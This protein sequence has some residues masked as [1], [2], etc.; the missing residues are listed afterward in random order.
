[1]VQRLHRRSPCLPPMFVCCLR[2]RRSAGTGS[3]LRRRRPEGI[4][5][6][7][8]CCLQNDGTQ[9]I[10]SCFGSSLE[11]VFC[12]AYPFI[13]LRYRSQFAFFRLKLVQWLKVLIVES[14]GNL[15]RISKWSEP[16]FV[17]LVE[18]MRG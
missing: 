11:A 18:V 4:W 15:M 8:A 17:F 2:S 7:S 5:C 1:M 16:R 6:D 9:D 3:V 10:F 12:S 13:S 14:I